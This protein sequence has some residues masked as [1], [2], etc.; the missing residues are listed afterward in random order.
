MSRAPGSRSPLIPLAILP[1][2]GAMLATG[3]MGI[4]PVLATEAI[5]TKGSQP[6]AQPLESSSQLVQSAQVAVNLEDLSQ[7]DA[8]LVESSPTLRRWLQQPPN[9][10]EE[11]RNHPLIPT[12]LQ[13]SIGTDNWGVGLEDIRLFDR[14]TVSGDFQHRSDQAGTAEAQTYGSNLRYYLALWIP[15][16]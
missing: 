12:R 15:G 16:R 7:E 10:L 9:L 2:V 8:G 5:E 1:W 11:I 4:W 13:A 6:E 3:L 14:L